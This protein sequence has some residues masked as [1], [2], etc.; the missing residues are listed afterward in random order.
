[1]K[2]DFEQKLYNVNGVELMEAP[3][4]PLTLKLAC[5]LGLMNFRPL[6]QGESLALD[7][8]LKRYKLAERIEK[9]KDLKSEDIVLIKNAVAHW[10]QNPVVTGAVVNALEPEADDE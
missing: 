9:N 8:Q 5:Q 3:D 4:A 10:F 6:R 1:M 7:E 2:I